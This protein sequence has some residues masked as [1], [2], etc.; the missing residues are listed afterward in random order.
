MN[1]TAIKD[2]RLE[3]WRLTELEQRTTKLEDRINQILFAVYAQVTIGSVA[4]IWHL[5]TNGGKL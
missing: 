5:A 1:D 2:R 3:D 4:L